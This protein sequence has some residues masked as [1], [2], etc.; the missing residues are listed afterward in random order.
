MPVVRAW[1]EHRRSGSGRRQRG[2]CDS[3][4]ELVF[5]L[6]SEFGFQFGR[7]DQIPAVVV[8]SVGDVFDPLVRIQIQRRRDTASDIEVG[9]LTTRGDIED[10]QQP[11][12]DTRCGG[13]RTQIGMQHPVHRSTVIGHMRPIPRLQSVS[14]DRDLASTQ[15]IRH[16]KRN[17]LLRQ[18]VGAVVV[19][20]AREPD[21]ALR[22]GRHIRAYYLVPRLPSLHCRGLRVQR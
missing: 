17:Q 5:G 4:L 8:R 9:D 2:L 11:R 10:R 3:G 22:A 19:G 6:P 15:Q 16:R 18:L 14:V 21:I 1:P 13:N 7:V 20:A 12:V